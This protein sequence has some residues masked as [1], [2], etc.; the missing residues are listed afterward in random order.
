[1]ALLA[2]GGS[3]N[4]APSLAMCPKLE[5]ITL[6]EM[7]GL[8]GYHFLTLPACASFFLSAD[9]VKALDL[10][11]PR[12]GSLHLSCHSLSRLRFH[13]AAA[14]S[15]GEARAFRAEAN[16]LDQ[17]RGEVTD[18]ELDAVLEQCRR[19]DE[20]EGEEEEDVDDD[21]QGNSSSGS[22]DDF[23]GSELGV[24]TI[25]SSTETTTT[26]SSNN[27][28]NNNEAPPRMQGQ[29]SVH[30]L[31]TTRLSFA[32]LT[33][34]QARVG[35]DNIEGANIC[36][37]GAQ[38]KE[39]S[40]SSSASGPSNGHGHDHGLPPPCLQLDDLSEALSGI[41]TSGNS[42]SST[43]ISSSRTGGSS[44]A[45]S[46]PLPGGNK[47]VGGG[48]SCGGGSG[49]GSRSSSTSPTWY[50]APPSPYF[51]PGGGDGVGRGGE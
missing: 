24:S 41:T 42:S 11:A 6:A 34:L 2:D 18:A 10:H 13:D 26:T 25:A 46:V 15:P 49:S 30:L 48:S 45:R 29:L 21:E 39:G 14:L 28:I 50:S 43:S 33:Q 51:A 35:A 32:S 47:G 44:G 36:G 20:E 16:A 4:F 12:L 7:N 31:G 37:L 8:G 1:M 27:N 40:Y 5:C 19:Q 38:G 3:D 17:L 23:S 22:D 9:D